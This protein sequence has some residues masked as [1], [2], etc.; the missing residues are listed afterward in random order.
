[1]LAEQIV[2]AQAAQCRRT[3]FLTS[4]SEPHDK[5]IRHSEPFSWYSEQYVGDQVLYHSL[6]D[7]LSQ[8]GPDA[9]L[10]LVLT[11][12]QEHRAD[13]VVV[14]SF[15]GLHDLVDDNLSLRKFIFGLGGALSVL[16][17][18][19]LL[20]GEYGQDEVRSYPELTVVD[21][22][23]YLSLERVGGEHRRWLEV[24]KLHGSNYLSGRH[25]FA[26]ADDG[27]TVY[28]RIASM[29][30]QSLYTSGTR[31]IS[32]GVPGLDPMF[33][34]GVFERSF[35]LLLG[36]PGTG[37][38]LL[39]LQ[40]LAEGVQSNGGGLLVS[41]HESPAHI[42]LQ[43]QRFGLNGGGMFQDER[44]QIIHHSAVDLNPDAVAA[45]IREAVERG[46]IRRLALDSVANLEGV[47][48][49]ATFRDFLVAL[50]TYLRS[51]GVTTLLMKEI[52]ELNGGPLSVAG[53]AASVTVDNILLLHYIELDGHLER[54]ISIV[55]ARES[56]SDY[57]LR[58]YS[59]SD[60]G[61]SV[62]EAFHGVEGIH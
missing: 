60:L 23:I 36:I 50:T 59:I 2:Y 24:T 55:K 44:V 52:S 8:G 47:M 42:R 12:A 25:R 56:A 9:A 57:S 34:G 61:M 15:R 48:D 31:R 7:S 46:G 35:T 14:D 49:Q 40:F 13:M 5:L 33:H 16:G 19:T 53:L 54:V 30:R 62:G 21:G 11:T 29:Y 22:L 1:M 18:T 10:D 43:A 6:Y 37:K 20:T 39:A 41:F 32:L 58:R 26:I 45:D 27:I 17:C 3:L 4:L 28:P 38:T 51:Q